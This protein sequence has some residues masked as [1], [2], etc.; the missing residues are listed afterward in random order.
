MRLIIQ[1]NPK[2][3][4]KWVANYIAR[5]II[6]AAPTCEKPGIR[7]FNSNEVRLVVLAVG[8]MLTN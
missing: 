7:C 5:K 4:S 8:Q 3:T 2:L 6:L 1:D